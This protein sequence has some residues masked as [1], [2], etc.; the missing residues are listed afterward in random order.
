MGQQYLDSFLYCCYHTGCYFIRSKLFHVFSMFRAICPS[1]V[2]YLL[3]NNVKS[4][5]LIFRYVILIKQHYHTFHVLVSNLIKHFDFLI[6]RQ[7]KTAL[8][9]LL[10]HIE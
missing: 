2:F 5:S 4:R 1:Y 10:P 8:F 6:E 3:K 9:V 7:E